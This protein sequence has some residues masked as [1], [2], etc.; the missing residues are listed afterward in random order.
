MPQDPVPAVTEAQATGETGR[1]FADIRAVYRVG[2]VNLIWRH[3]ATIPE[4]LP[5]AWQAIRPLYVDGTIAR[6]AVT[7]R[8]SLMLPQLTPVP[9]EALTALGLATDDVRQIQRVLGAYD[10]TNG[11]ALIA[12]TAVSVDGEDRTQT[13]PEPPKPVDGDDFVELPPLTPLSAMPADTARLIEL[14]N[15]F[16]TDAPRPILAS[17]YRHLS[18]WPAYLA[19]TWAVLAPLH[20]SR[21]LHSAIADTAARAD[22]AARAIATQMQRQPMPPGVR[23]AI[24]PF[25]GDVLPK[26]VAIC[27]MLRTMTTA[28]DA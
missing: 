11:M 1:I 21:T 3:L 28:P 24:A 17:M 15:S 19:L 10:R 23:E 12:L 4:G 13:I 27:G 5:W 7:L 16:G 2:A 20:A 14:L 25:I 6:A 18:H 22:A 8:S 26:M 9:A